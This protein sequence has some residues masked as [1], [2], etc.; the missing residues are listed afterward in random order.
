M[1]HAYAKRGMQVKA[2]RKHKEF[3]TAELPFL[4]L[5]LLLSILNFS[6]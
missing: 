4:P 1:I 5:F 3:L 2:L 6:I